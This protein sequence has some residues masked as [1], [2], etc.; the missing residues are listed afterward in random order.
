MVKKVIHI[1][2]NALG[3][4][5]ILIGLISFSD[6]NSWWTITIILGVVISPWIWK[7][8]RKNVIDKSSVENNNN[9]IEIKNDTIHK[10]TFLK[11]SLLL[12]ENDFTLLN[13]LQ[14]DPEKWI[15]WLILQLWTADSQ[16][17][18]KLFPLLEGIKDHIDINI[19]KK[20]S[21]E[22]A[23]GLWLEAL[24]DRMISDEEKDN[25]EKVV[26]LGE[27]T[28]NDIVN[29][30]QVEFNDLYTSFLI[31]EKGILPDVNVTTLGINLS[32]DEIAH[33]AGAAILTQRKMKTFSD[34]SY[35]GVSYNFKIMKWIS[36]RVGQIKRNSF[37]KEVLEQIDDGVIIISS[38]RIG[39][40][41]KQQNFRIPYSKIISFWATEDGLTIMKENAKKPYTLFMINY[42]VPLLVLSKIINS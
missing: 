12:S 40:V 37:K 2:L 19:F 35:S 9:H 11:R 39:F 14:N 33:Y 3:A 22:I 30:D 26:N 32:K 23:E 42:D 5:L 8:I 36:Y 20:A 28:L 27:L 21:K 13:E 16:E 15:Q 38:K 31:Q 25:F 7:L 10:D 24:S 41:W 29:F 6:T 34:G 4:L 18:T 1:I 17:F